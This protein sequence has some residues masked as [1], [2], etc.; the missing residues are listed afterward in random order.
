MLWEPT[1]HSDLRTNGVMIHRKIKSLRRMGERKDGIKFEAESLRGHH[2]YNVR[3]Q[4]QWSTG[5][6][7]SVL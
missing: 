2:E 7:Y 1:C 5:V 6:V 3:L 4:R